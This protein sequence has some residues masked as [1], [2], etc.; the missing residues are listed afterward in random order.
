MEEEQRHVHVSM[1]S[2]SVREQ[3]NS[4]PL[5]KEG[6]DYSEACVNNGGAEKLTQGEIGVE[7]STLAQ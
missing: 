1:H 6:S 2:A 3:G 5:D 7:K 4:A